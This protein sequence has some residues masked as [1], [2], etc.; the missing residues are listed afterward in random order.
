MAHSRTVQTPMRKVGAS[1]CYGGC[2]KK[3]LAVLVLTIILATFTAPL[4]AQQSVGGPWTVSVHGMSLAM[5]LSQSG[6]G[7]SGTLDSPHGV[8]QIKGEFSK[9]KL[10]FTAVSA[11]APEL[12][13]AAYATLNPDGSLSGN[14]SVNLMDLTFTAVRS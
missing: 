2:M 12:Q 1:Q 11:E 7:I 3:G 14:I 5:N 4:Q 8:L 6:D 10:T 13:L 9:G